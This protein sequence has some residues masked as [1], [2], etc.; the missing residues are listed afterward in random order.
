[1][2]AAP[3]L[4]DDN[5]DWSAQADAASQSDWANHF[6][7]EVPAEAIG[8]DLVHHAIRQAELALGPRYSQRAVAGILRAV[9]PFPSSS[10][11][12]D[13]PLTREEIDRRVAEGD[14]SLL[15][16]DR[17]EADWL[18]I[19]AEHAHLFG[20]ALYG[21]VTAR[22]VDGARARILESI[23]RYQRLA[24]DPSARAAVGDKLHWITDILAAAEARWELDHDRPVPPAGLAML[25][26]VK[27]KTMA[28]LLAARELATDAR[29][30]GLPDEARRYLSGRESFIPSVWQRE[31]EYRAMA[32]AAEAGG[33]AA[34]RGEQVFVPVDS[35]GRA[36]L[37]DLARQGRD[38]IPRY[39]IGP[40]DAPDFVEDY[41]E[42]LHRL[43]LMETPRWRRPPATGKGGWSLV[44]AQEGW[45]RFPRAEL[46]R[47]LAAIRPDAA[48]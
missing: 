30:H 5:R 15:D 42:A 18:D 33:A 25:A 35:E 26:G 4:H 6:L 23:G 48:G 24:A 14:A 27:P 7:C 47:M 29:G 38:G 19:T 40:K 37:P 39:A 31:E 1:M 46:E 17:A 13:E 44:S 9:G 16:D 32:E 20:Y 2:T 41:W 21:D 8:R 28:N 43:S 45:R 36:F 3:R 34:R 10:G 11:H 22:S 12:Y